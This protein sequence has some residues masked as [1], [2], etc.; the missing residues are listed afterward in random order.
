MPAI[1][2]SCLPHPKEL[3]GLE[4]MTGGSQKEVQ[5]F[6]CFNFCDLHTYSNFLVF[7]ICFLHWITSAHTQ[8]LNTISYSM[9]GIKVYSCASVQLHIYTTDF[10]SAVF[11]FIWTSSQS[12]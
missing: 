11:V 8:P 1:P 7:C 12:A 9:N 6:A 4:D 2:V 10:F 5:H 3:Y